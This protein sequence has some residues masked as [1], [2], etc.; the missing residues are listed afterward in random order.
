SEALAMILGRKGYQVETVNDGQ[1]AMEAMETDSYDVVILDI[2]MPKADGIS[3]LK[4]IREKG[5]LTPVL[6]LTAKSEVDDKVTGLE[7]GANDYLTKPFS[8]RELMARIGAITRA[9]IFQNH[10][11]LNM[12][13]TTL[14]RETFELSTP[15]GALRLANKE[16]L[17]LEMMMTNPGGQISEDRF[18]EKIWGEESGAEPGNERMYI[19]YLRKKL[20]VLHADIQI[21]E[22]ETGKIVLRGSGI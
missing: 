18:L 3:V 5:D 4:A 7:A 15:A 22:T 8:S 19:S 12:G 16:F 21:K 9:Q 17:M 14:D 1:E 13:N 10:P 2:M 6:L 20:Q 11:K